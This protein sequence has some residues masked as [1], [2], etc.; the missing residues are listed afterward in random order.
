[1]SFEGGLLWQGQLCVPADERIKENLLT[2]AHE[3][4]YS[5]HPGSTKMYRDLK[6]CY[7]WPGMKRDVAL[8]VSRCL[9]CQQVKAPR[10][11]PSGLLQPLD[12][13]QWKW[14]DIA[15]DFVTGLPK[16]SKGY[17]IIW[18]IIDRLTKSVHLSPVRLLTQGI[19]GR[20]YIWNKLSDCMGFRSPL[21]QIEIHVLP[22][23]FG[24]V[25]KKQWGP[26]SDSVQ[27]STPRLMAKPKAK[28]GLRR[29]IASMRD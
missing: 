4:L 12:I 25:C 2:E 26:N 10:M 28:L 6:K 17:T 11:R 13:L 1:M 24:K 7:W 3:S 14:E 20:S 5:V 8:K 22:P 15:M 27:R 23:T 29:N 21:C 9:T 16:T 18:V 19:N